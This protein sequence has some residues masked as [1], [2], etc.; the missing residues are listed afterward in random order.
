[1]TFLDELR[2]ARL[3][4]ISV[5]HQFLLN[6]PNSPEC[7]HVFFEGQGDYSF[8]TGFLRRFIPHPRCLFSYK[9]GNKTNLYETYSKVMSASPQG[10]ALFFVD[11]DFS[12]IL[13]ESYPTAGNIYVTDYYSIE[14]YLVSEDMLIRVWNEIFHIPNATM[15]ISNTQ[16]KFLE[17]LERFYEFILPVAAWIVCLRRSGL[18]PDLNNINLARFFYINNNLTLEKQREIIFE[19]GIDILDQMCGV[20]TP[21]VCRLDS[22]SVAKELADLNPKMYVRGK[23]ELWFFVK[24]IQ[25]LIE[26][27]HLALSEMG[28]NVRVRTPINE[29]NAI[30]V[31]GPRLQ[32]PLSL[33]EFLR[34]NLELG[35]E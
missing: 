29:G 34:R 4:P 35:R 21:V 12:D 17:E 19:D 28:E 24:F 3:S 14:N 6:N 16:I 8:Y 33:E 22:S 7:I 30:E 11:K 5:Y 26:A 10:I 32:I 18:N 23:F 25:R 1:M 13:N 15:N 20:T 31:L 2:C 9:C 27:L